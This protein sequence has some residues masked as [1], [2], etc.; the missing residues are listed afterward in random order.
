MHESGSEQILGYGQSKVLP[1]RPFLNECLPGDLHGLLFANAILQTE[2]QHGHPDSSV[3]IPRMGH[4]LFD[5][6]D[7]RLSSSLVGCSFWSEFGNHFRHSD[8]EWGFFLL[9]LGFN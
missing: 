3:H 8:G 6:P 4:H 5:F 2:E 9:L 7:D 1:L